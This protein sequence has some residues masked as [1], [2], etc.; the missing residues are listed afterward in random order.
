VVQDL[1]VHKKLK[2]LVGE[3]VTLECLWRKRTAVPF[4]KKN[5][6]RGTLGGGTQDHNALGVLQVKAGVLTK[7]RTL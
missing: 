2:H 7:K 3:S 1:I 5:K 6:I 4:A